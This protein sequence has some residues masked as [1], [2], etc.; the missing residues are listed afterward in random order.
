MNPLPFTLDTRLAADTVAIVD[1]PLS[2]VRLMRDARYPWVIL[3]P[4]KTGLS[5]L[6][7]LPRED[8]I[9]VMD[10][11]AAVS[12][13]LAAETGCLKLNVAAIGNIVRQLH[14]HVI[15]RNEGDD[16]WP[17]P[18]WGKHPPIAYAAQ[19]ETDLVK[20]LASRLGR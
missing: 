17:G 2:A 18:V 15:A 13:A 5:E 4:R 9:Q 8:R 11:I 6:T 14:I 10:E 3:I 16:A 7:D 19:I 12:N 1:L 20:R